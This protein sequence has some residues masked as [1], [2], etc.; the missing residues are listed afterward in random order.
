MGRTKC[1]V[2]GVEITQENDSEAHVIPNALGGH[3]KPKGI[4]SRDANSILNDKFDSPLIEAFAPIMSLLGGTKDRGKIQPTKMQNEQGQTYLYQFGQSL[5][6]NEPTFIEKKAVLEG[7]T[8]YTIE[9][10]T[11]K[12]ARTLLG[13]VKKSY[14]EID[15]DEILKH[16]TVE[17][18]PHQGMLH[19]RLEIGANKT[20][21]AAFVMA[22]IFAASHGLPMHPQ[23]QSYVDKFTP[24]PTE[25]S[26][27]WVR[28]Y[29]PPDTF[30]FL[31]KNKRWFN[32]KATVGH[33]LIYFANPE[34]KK[35][36]FYMELFNITSIA[37]IL[38]FD[39]TVEVLQTYA[40][41]VLEGNK[42][43][44]NIDLDY[45][46]KTIWGETHPSGG[47]TD[48]FSNIESR[49]GMV[50]G[51]SQRRSRELL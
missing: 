44:V 40:F 33:I 3:L 16:A 8:H 17:Q 36:I 37:V 4:L 19:K 27:E 22:S 15:I 25:G 47:N 11:M 46:K 39:G 48:L 21:P 1:I 42:I 35:A 2:T 32:A 30:Y 14:P 5:K 6:A 50:I 28:E 43:A 20:F 29:M 10:R 26:S 24:A 9:A 31:P 45:L 51:E 18:K 23:F 49:L 7:G 13:R 41:D 12:E 34:S 38:P